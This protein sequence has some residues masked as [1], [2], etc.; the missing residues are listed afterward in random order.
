MDGPA[1]SPGG[2]SRRPL[3]VGRAREQA[4]LR[5]RLAAALV[6][7]GGLVLI[8]GEAG[9]GKTALA[10]ALGCEAVEQ[11]ARMV[12]GRCYE[13]TETPPYGPWTELLTHCA[14]LPDMPPV[15]IDMLQPHGAGER[16]GQAALFA[17]VGDVL[18]AAA[19]QHPLVL[20]LDD[21][22]WADPAS[23]DLLCV[24]A[25]R[26]AALS[27]LLLVTYR[28]DELSR[29]H[30]L[31]HLLPVLVR[32]TDAARLDLR[33]LT[34]YDVRELVR[35]RYSLPVADEDRLVAYLHARAEGNPF[36]IGELL[37]TLEE[38]A[39]LRPQDPAAHWV[40]DDLTQARLPTLLRQ[41]LD[42][43]LD[44][45]G[46][47]A[48]ELLAM[49]AVIGQEAPL[50]LWG[51]LS[52]IPEIKLLE[53]VEHAAKARLLE[54]TPDGARIRF[55]HAL[56]REA[57]YTGLAPSRRRLWHR[58]VGAAL[59]AM[60]DPDPDQVAHQFRQAGDARALAWLIRA[61]ERA[62][63]AYALLTAADRFEAA[64]TLMGGDEAGSAE[65]GW[66]LFRLAW[67]RRFADQQ[68]GIAYLDE[69]M[70][71][72]ASLDDDLL[73]AHALCLRG[74]LYAFAGDYVRG[75]PDLTAGVAAMEIL[76][77]D[78]WQTASSA[79]GLADD[80]RSDYRGMLAI[81]LALTGQLSEARTRAERMI[82]GLP[83]AVAEQGAD[84]V[85]YH[86]YG[87]AYVGLAFAEAHQGRPDEARR[88][89]EQARALYLRSGE[90][91]PQ[92]MVL[93]SDLRWV[94][95]PY[96]A[97]SV[98]ERRRF[99]DEAE[100]AFAQATDAQSDFPPRAAR[101]PLLLLEGAWSDARHVA[102]A[103]DTTRTVGT[104]RRLFS[105]TELGLLA[106]WQGDT[107]VAWTIVREELPA[108]PA[109][110]PGESYFDA[111][112]AAQRL[113]AAL[114]IDAGDLGTAQAWLEAHDRWLAWS[115]S[116]LGQADSHHSW[117]AYHRAAGDPA[118][119]D[120]HAAQAL[121]CASQPR[122]PLVLLAAHR[123]LG[124]LA[125]DAE[126]YGDADQRLRAA[127]ALA[128]ACAAPYER[129]LT[130]LALAAL[131]AVTGQPAAALAL[132]EEAQTICILLGA[133]P[134]LAR[135]DALAAHIGALTP[136][137]T[138]PTGLTP[139]EREVLRL[140]VAGRSNRE[141]AETLFI[142]DRTATTHV[143]NILHK[144]GVE[145]RAA[146]V[147]YAYEHGL[148]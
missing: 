75:L 2:S 73:T 7:E 59:A 12:V 65:R 77:V 115:G 49:A 123:L 45:L 48:R 60:V 64:L 5:D 9:I 131:Q 69:V 33:P 87:D 113:A 67:L 29:R 135:A 109:T 141:I 136:A 88:A 43:R 146:A 143:S 70:R 119:A 111:G 46:E 110:P 21:M 61:G 147:A 124:E 51:Q 13:L 18:A 139:R 15:P 106:R 118:P 129:A 30:P 56:I 36:F 24:L 3:L 14:A 47:E 126:R 23:L 85:R 82:A 130:L 138:D 1:A 27:L 17:Q 120:C 10:D 92:S 90:L 71:I 101:L 134:A 97:E 72:A 112:L 103:L 32:E 98:A 127:L 83:A 52:A 42:G 108:G 20:L 133:A 76:P 38:E 66:V 57:L 102:L 79:S 107:E 35:A 144:L 89:F 137:C 19:A 28:S 54:E 8:S 78:A 74:W 6:G 142:G 34:G 63:R 122:Q 26:L 55:V 40:L 80:R 125:T 95:V 39:L 121:T 114:A 50:A 11:G 37:R 44:R 116:V 68:Q 104:W 93:L 105:V 31:H 16:A 96:F 4:L 128:D 62:E 132:V 140:L 86:F 148:V 91:L 53:V 41:V 94:V 84:R 58:Q 22:H 99:A 117:A 100:A 25:R 81:H 145:S